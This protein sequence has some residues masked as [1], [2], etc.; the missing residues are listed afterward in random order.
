MATTPDYYAGDGPPADCTLGDP[1]SVAELNARVVETFGSYVVDFH[2]GMRCPADVLDRLHSNASGQAKR[3]D[4]AFDVLVPEP[5]IA[6]CNGRPATIV[7][8]SGPDRIVGGPDGD[9]L[10]GGGGDDTLFGDGGRNVVRGA[11]G[12]DAC[13]PGAPSSLVDRGCET[14][15]PPE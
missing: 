2:D 12:V 11:K 13:A 14:V 1:V 15:L 8:T 6:R 4:A 10:L 7:G 9:I 3:A 5:R